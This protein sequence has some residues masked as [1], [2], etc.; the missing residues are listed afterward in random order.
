MTIMT[1]KYPNCA[2]IGNSYSQKTVVIDFAGSRPSSFQKDYN[3]TTQKNVWDYFL[4]ELH[5]LANKKKLHYH[6][7]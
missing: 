6:L 2:K 7:V 5:N 3:S 4:I 1:R